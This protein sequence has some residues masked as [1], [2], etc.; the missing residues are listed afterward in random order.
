[1]NVPHHLDTAETILFAG[2][3]HGNTHHLRYLIDQAVAHQADRIIQVGDFGYWAHTP[4][5]QQF[6]D[7]VANYAEQHQMPVGFIDGNHEN[8]E[9]LQRL[10]EHTDPDTQT[11]PIANNGWLHWIPRGTRI[12]IAGHQFG[13][14]GGAFSIDHMSRTQGVSWWPEEEPTEADLNRLGTDPLDVLVTHDVPEGIYMTSHIN[15]S[16]PTENR[17]R[18]T[19]HLLREAVHRTQPQLVIAGHWHQRQTKQIP[20]TTTTVEVLNCD[21]TGPESWILLNTTTLAITNGT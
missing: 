21:G 9:R 3:T 17:A 7:D 16:W 20:D 1:M 8:H 11:V 10:A 19:R 13:F 12:A 5:G 18:A 2:D 15:L 14:L 4:D 6:L